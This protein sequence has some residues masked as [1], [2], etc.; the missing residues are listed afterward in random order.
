M[1]AKSTSASSMTKAEKAQIEIKRKKH[2][3]ILL[4]ARLTCNSCRFGWLCCDCHLGCVACKERI[5][6][7]LCKYI[8]CIT[9]GL[10]C[11]MCELLLPSC[12]CHFQR[13]CKWCTVS[14]IEC[15]RGGC[16]HW[17]PGRLTPE[18][19]VFANI[20]E[21]E[22]AEDDDAVPDKEEMESAEEDTVNVA[23]SGEKSAA[24]KVGHKADSGKSCSLSKGDK[25]T[26]SS[27]SISSVVQ[28]VWWESQREPEQAS[29]AASSDS[30][31]RSETSLSS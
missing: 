2:E 23:P 26:S 9:P 29:P 16:I 15:K 6:L 28:S 24:N 3:E 30:D 5:K 22:D 31:S 21:R 12:T 1:D 4:R 8:A 11:R 7:C 14:L 10:W 25:K 13:N 20:F 18:A 17:L 19:L 27:D